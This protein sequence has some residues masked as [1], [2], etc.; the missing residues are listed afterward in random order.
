MFDSYEFTFAGES[1]LMYGLM[2]YDIDGKGQSNVAF[3]NKGS[4]IETRTNRRIQPLHF[5]VNYNE[6]PLQFNLVFGAMEPLDRY[7]LQRISM[8]LTGH[9]S[10]QW[11]SIDQP[12]MNH[13]QFRCIITQLTPLSYGWL[14]Y[15]F[16][17]TV[18]CDCPYAYSFLFEKQY[19]INGA[20]NIVFRNESTVREY[21]KPDITFMP[22]GGTTSLSIVNASDNN[23]EFLL[24]GIRTS[25]T[26]VINNNS[27]IIR[28][29]V[30]GQNLY[31]GFNYKFFRLVH[32]DNN[33]T[34]TGNGSLMISGRYLY[35]VAG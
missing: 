2:I 12:D 11:L 26:V 10:Y 23:R 17:A 35:N 19:T 34:V 9:Q 30:F 7:D 28:E 31:D 1:S 33:L 15:A 20:T 27:G 22:S 18:T 14:P 32:G 13:L 4:I 6:S 25:A 5:G 24:E 21:L 3:G 8:W 16:E 29:T